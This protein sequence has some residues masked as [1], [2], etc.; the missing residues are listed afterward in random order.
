MLNPFDALHQ[1][2]R[3]EAPHQVGQLTIGCT[4]YV[5]VVAIT[6]VRSVRIHRSIL[7]K[8]QGRAAV[9]GA[10]TLASP[11]AAAGGALSTAHESVIASYR[12]QSFE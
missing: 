3:A 2:A 5:A 11:L 4:D 7:A 8:G 1:A 12:K 9:C 10:T 6:Q